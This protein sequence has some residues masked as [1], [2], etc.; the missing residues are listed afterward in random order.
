M[1]IFKLSHAF[2][3]R[4][5]YSAAGVA[6]TVA[7]EALEGGGILLL[8]CGDGALRDFLDV[9][10]KPARIEG[11]AL[12]HGHFDHLGGLHTILGFLRMI[13]RNNALPVAYPAGCI[14]VEAF[15]DRF[16]EL[17]PKTTFPITRLPLTDGGEARIAPWTL[18]AFAVKHAGSTAAG[19]LDPI[20]AMGYRVELGGNVVAYSGDTGPCKNLG[21]LCRGADL[22]LIEA[23]WGDREPQFKRRVHLTREEAESYGRLAKRFEL[24][25]RIHPA[26]ESD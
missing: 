12:S 9:G 17:Y 15:L 24:I 22:A 26:E 21:K 18:K 8:D 11:I 19:V 10:L 16:E 20:P 1:K 25:H 6:T 2:T 14:E 3:V 7:L 5:L 23:T 13:G 4:V